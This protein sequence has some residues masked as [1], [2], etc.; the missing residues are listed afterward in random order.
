MG[1]TVEN[2]S[3]EGRASWREQPLRISVQGLCGAR[4]ARST[5]KK[6]VVRERQV[7]VNMNGR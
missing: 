2:A 3:N 4:T 7:L 5:L 6:A 1:A